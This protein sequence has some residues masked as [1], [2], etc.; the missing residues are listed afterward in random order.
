MPTFKSQS[1]LLCGFRG[2]ILILV[3]ILGAAAPAAEKTSVAVYPFKAVGTVDKSVAATIT[4]LVN[5]ELTQSPKLLVI[6]EDMLQEVMKRQAM[7]IS[8]LCDSTMCQVEIGKLVA[9]Q[10]M[11]TGELSKL[12]NRYIMTVNLVDIQTGTMEMSGKEQCTCT[13]DQLDQ[14]AALASAKIREHF[15]ETG[16]YARKAAQASAPSGAPQ[17]SGSYRPTRSAE[18]ISA[19]TAAKIR[20]FE[21]IFQSAN[22]D[23]AAESSALERGGV[24][25]VKG[26][27]G[28]KNVAYFSTMVEAPASLA[29]EAIT[30]VENYCEF[31]PGCLSVNILE[32]TSDHVVIQKMGNMKT[33]NHELFFDHSIM[34]MF[35]KDL[36]NTLTAGLGVA[37]GFRGYKIEALTDDRSKLI[38]AQEGRGNVQDD[39]KAFKKRAEAL[40]R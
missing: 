10:K 14:L 34:E 33:S 39:L 25:S 31:M 13:E 26:K 8:D 12:G 11:V 23:S 29:W 32:R 15:G 40:A 35:C 18:A 28:D 7:N 17:S 30:D 5:Y 9:A 4:S 16:I 6:K 37:G 21:K 36:D 38:A 22:V 2:L 1:S 24:Y 27:S 20:R 19:E 3:G